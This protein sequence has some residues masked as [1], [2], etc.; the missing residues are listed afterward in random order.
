MISWY[1][2]TAVERWLHN[3]VQYL[4]FRYVTNF[5]ELYYRCGWFL[6]NTCIK[7]CSCSMSFLLLNFSSYWPTSFRMHNAHIE[8]KWS[9]V[10]HPVNLAFSMV[11]VRVK[12]QNS[13]SQISFIEFH[14]NDASAFGLFTDRTG[15]VEMRTVCY[16]LTWKARKYSI[17]SQQEIVSECLGCEEI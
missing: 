6:Q 12:Y 16:A 14:L 5:D 15:M 4:G 3:A 2:D 13:A 8:C 11:C 1:H 9:F 17:A 7:I 10:K